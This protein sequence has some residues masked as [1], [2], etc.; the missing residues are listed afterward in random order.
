MD[1][2]EEAVKREELRQAEEELRKI[3]S[4]IAAPEGSSHTS[5]IVEVS[6]MR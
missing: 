3:M 5:W 4:N 1:L 2:D 6:Y